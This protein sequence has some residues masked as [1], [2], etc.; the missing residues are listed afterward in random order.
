MATPCEIL[1]T[2]DKR[3]GERFQRRKMEKTTDLVVGCVQRL[4]IVVLNECVEG[5]G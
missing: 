2:C 5:D 4:S 1:R 3:D